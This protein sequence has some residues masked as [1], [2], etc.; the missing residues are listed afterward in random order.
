[1]MMIIIY[2]NKLNNDND[3]NDNDN[4]NIMHMI[5]IMIYKQMAPYH[6]TRHDAFED[7]QSN[8]PLNRCKK[9]QIDWISSNA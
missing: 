2:I 6:G 9:G 3:N 8:L 4:I 5:M 7:T 1:M